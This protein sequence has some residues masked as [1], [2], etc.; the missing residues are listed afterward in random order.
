MKYPVAT[1]RVQLN[2]DF[3]FSKAEALIPYLVKLGISDLY[4]SPVFAARPGSTHGYDVIDPCRANPE[5]GGNEGFDR[6][7]AA[8]RERGLGLVL[9][10]VP[11]HMA[12]SSD[13]AWWMDVLENGVTS[14]YAAFFDVEWDPAWE[15]GEEKIFLPVLG[16]AYGTVLE[17]GELKLSIDESGFRINYYETT[18]PVDCGTYPLILEHRPES[19]P[20]DDA[21]RLLI[22]QF[23]RLPDRHSRMWEGIEARR[24]EIPAIKAQLWSRYQSSPAVREFIDTNIALFNGKQGEPRSFD[25][26]DGLISRQA[27]RLAW[28][29]VARERMNYRRFFD[30]SALIGVRV[31]N[32]EVFARTHAQ[33]IEWVRDG[34]ATGLRVDHVD[35]LFKPREYLERL[36]A[37]ENRPYLVV[38]KILLEDERLPGDWPI[39]G[40]SGYDF[41]GAANGVLIDGANLDR[42][43]DTYARF[44]GL[45][46]TVEDAAYQQKRWIIRHLFRGEMFAVSLHLELIADMDRHGRDLSP[47]ELRH[48]IAEITACLPVYR[49][50]MVEDGVMPEQDRAY[51]RQAVA[52]AQRRNPEISEASFA[53]L[54]RVLT[55][56]MPDGI[57]DDDRRAWIRFVMRWQQLT[58]PITAKGVEDT[59]MYVYNRL[60]S[61]N[62][63]GGYHTDVP[64]ERF[65]RFNTERQRRWPAAMNTISTHDTKRSADV[66]ARLDVLSEL[67]DEWDRALLRWSRW[68]RDKK[69][70]ID[71]RAVPDGNEEILIYQTLLGA[72]PLDP[73]EEPGFIDRVKQYLTKAAREA[74]VYTTWLSPNEEH[75][76]ALHRFTEAILSSDGGN[77]FLPKFR[78][79]QQNIAYFGALNS[80]TQTLLMMTCPGIP[81][82]YQNTTIWDLTLVDPDNRRPVEIDTR[83]QLAE[84][85]SAWTEQ[86]AAAAQLLRSWTDGRIKTYLIHR[87][88]QFR[89]D[90]PE[91]FI[92]A[93]YAP[94][95]ATGTFANNV[96]AFERSRDGEH[97]IVVAPRFC[98]RLVKAGKPPV[99]A[100]VWRDTAVPAI[101]GEWRNV[102]TGERVTSQDVGSVLQTFPMALLTNFGF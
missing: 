87:V 96:I 17:N 74:K 58:G 15:R 73:A 66:R 4:A 52:E 2:K 92:E 62:E 91:F 60:V 9:D 54:E 71:G 56:G 55:C 65:H 33:I 99:G 86:S 1:Y 22:E 57:G 47:E 81:D 64:L 85:V 19:S 11:N 80:L 14:E 51:I 100:K 41:L 70:M 29:K 8:L 44:T 102:I 84:E 38:E 98:T 97:C 49:T 31:E 101:E 7:S 18:L 94:L 78:E 34:K 79:F 10:I 53:F 75:E 68:N 35:G 46:W 30:V 39:E 59:T 76:A 16:S 5:L 13:N 67:P 40:T 95:D 36:S 45:N 21:F 26:L 89:C 88:L 3:P 82:F 77:R 32:P 37:I 20:D 24:R 90:H 42:L 83:L 6:L 25:L 43:Q 72:W 48:G 93:N 23:G 27:Y 61:M 50:Y 69:T 63:V 12:A 28:W